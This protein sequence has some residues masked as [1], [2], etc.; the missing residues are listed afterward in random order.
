MYACESPIKSWK[1]RELCEWVRKYERKKER[2][3]ERE[4]GFKPDSLMK[5]LAVYMMGMPLTME[6]FSRRR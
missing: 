1:L 4:R 2:E 6:L 5:Q 3:R